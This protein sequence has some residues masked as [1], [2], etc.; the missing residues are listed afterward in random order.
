MLWRSAP[1]HHQHKHMEAIIKLVVSGSRW[2]HLISNSWHI[3]TYTHT[4]V[5]FLLFSAPLW[6]L[7]SWWTPETWA[8]AQT[9]VEA[10]HFRLQLIQLALRL[11]TYSVSD[12]DCLSLSIRSHTQYYS[13]CFCQPYIWTSARSR[14]AKLKSHGWEPSWENI[15]NW[16][17]ETQK[18]I[19]ITYNSPSRGLGNTGGKKQCHPTSISHQQIG[20]SQLELLHHQKSYRLELSDA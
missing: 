11:Y 2:N 16:L 17:Q 10:L 5:L 12:S 19:V 15:A 9:C 18:V 13:M 7:A 6:P 20:T 8:F 1:V 14:K 3:H 4:R